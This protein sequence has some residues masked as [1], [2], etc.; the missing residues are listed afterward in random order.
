MADLNGMSSAIH[1]VNARDVTI[2]NFAGG[3]RR[4]AV[5]VPVLG[6]G[7]V[8]TQIW[9]PHYYTEKPL[10]NW[11]ME[12][13]GGAEIPV[14]ASPL[15][16]VLIRSWTTKRVPDSG[17]LL[18]QGCRATIRTYSP[19]A[20]ASASVATR[21]SFSLFFEGASISMPSKE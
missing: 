2:A 18:Y 9:F 16:T 4:F 7:E 15:A 21:F 12:I 1:S 11:G 5:D 10:H 19:Y 20:G 14:N 8:T 13:A 6:I 3:L 17:L